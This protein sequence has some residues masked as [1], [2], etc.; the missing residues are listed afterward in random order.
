M[1]LL[2]QVLQLIFVFSFLFT[3][4]FASVDWHDF[5]VVETVD[6]KDSETGKT[7]INHDIPCDTVCGMVSAML[8]ALRSVSINTLRQGVYS[9]FNSDCTEQYIIQPSVTVD[10]AK[11]YLG[12][13]FSLLCY[14]GEK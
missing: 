11:F 4:A 14:K 6:F 7:I 2:I 13:D 12:C 8:E 3:V 1:I 5:V 10:Q 9:L